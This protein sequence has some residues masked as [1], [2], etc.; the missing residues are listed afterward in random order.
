V[1]NYMRRVIRLARPGAM[2]TS[3]RKIWDLPHEDLGA[4][5]LEPVDQRL[6][7]LFGGHLA[8]PAARGHGRV[9]QRGQQLDHL[10]ARAL[11]LPAKC[12]GE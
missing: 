5:P 3:R 1:S 8:A 2:R 10:Y 11:E 7:D 9:D 4:V 6:R 12:R